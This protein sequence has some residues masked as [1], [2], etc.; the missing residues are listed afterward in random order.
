MHQVLV[1]LPDVDR[2]LS[3]SYHTLSSEPVQYTLMTRICG[4]TDSPE[5]KRK[6]ENS[7]KDLLEPI[8]RLFLNDAAAAAAIERGGVFER[9][10][11]FVTFSADVKRWESSAGVRVVTP[12][13]PDKLGVVEANLHSLTRDFGAC[14]AIPLLYGQDFLDRYS[15]LLDDFWKFDNDIFPLLMMGIPSWAPLR[16]MKEGLAARSRLVNEL[17]ALYRRID[18]HQRGE[19]VDFGADMSDVSNVALERNKVYN[20]E[21][22]SFQRRGEGDLAVL[23]GQNANTQPMLF[24]FLAFVYSTAGLLPRLREEIAPYVKLSQTSPLEIL[25][26][27][28]LGLCRDCLL[29][30]ACIFETYRM[31]NEPASVRYVARPITVKD[32]EY[33]HELKRGTF[34]TAAHSLIQRDPSV[35]TSPDNF[36]PNRF[37]KP[38][39]E[40]GKLSARYGALKPWGSG[41]AACKG[42]TF[43]EKEIVALGTAVISLWDIGPASGT[44]D[45]PAMVPGMGA[46]KPVKDVR[47]VITRR[48]LL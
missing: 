21:H 14:L 47:V 8:E 39:P 9:A 41:T 18:Q 13:L 6:S 29:M 17:E 26:M 33:N 40:S 15:Q 25:S 34:V 7:W 11:S 19:P 35:Y 23:W 5:L 4:A 28:L 43:A 12:D 16:V 24:W 31:A 3:Q 36:E 22:W 46:K 2:L 32:G 30:K 37:L 48:V 1:N 45:L 27:N 44:W 42:R 38:D 20:R 10:A